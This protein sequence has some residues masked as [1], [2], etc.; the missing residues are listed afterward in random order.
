[1]G[2]LEGCVI[3]ILAPVAGV[4]AGVLILPFMKKLPP[5]KPRKSGKMKTLAAYFAIGWVARQAF[6]LSKRTGAGHQR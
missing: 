5:Y 1:M 3:L 6:S 4:L 2:C